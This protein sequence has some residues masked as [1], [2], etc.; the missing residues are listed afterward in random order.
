MGKIQIT[1]TQAFGS[2]VIEEQ[3][4]EI[5]IAPLNVGKRQ[6]L[7]AAESTS[8][9]ATEDITLT[10]NSNVIQLVDT[11]G[12][13]RVITLPAVGLNNHG[14]LI[15]NIG[16]DDDEIITVKNAS[17]T[18]IGI[19]YAGSVAGWFVSSGTAWRAAGVGTTSYSATGIIKTVTVDTNA[20]GIGAPLFIAADGHYDTA[21]ADSVTTMPCVALALEAGTGSKQV[22]LM[23]NV[24]N[25]NWNWTVGPGAAGHIYVDTTVGT[26][27][28]TMPTGTDDV[29]QP[30][31]Y[32]ISATEMMFIPSM[33]W[34]THT[35]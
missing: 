16:E 33:L 5:T 3:T 32:A 14:F 18:T 24:M 15:F 25:A 27:T 35:G 26:L 9:T 34:V 8:T 30:V 11:N 6:M 4:R 19:V 29:V 17:G 31:G 2:Q 12:S 1:V 13:S 28:Q 10:D 21:D 22:L 7:E 20:E 23:G